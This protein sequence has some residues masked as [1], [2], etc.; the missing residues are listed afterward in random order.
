MNGY[1]LLQAKAEVTLQQGCRYGLAQPTNTTF[2][3]A[4]TPSCCSAQKDIKGAT[5][6]NTHNALLLNRE[7]KVI[8]VRGKS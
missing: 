1:Q 6:Q 7:W 3:I 4:Q 8:I 2:Y 5:K